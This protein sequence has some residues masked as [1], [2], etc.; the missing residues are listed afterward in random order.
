M[1]QFPVGSICEIIVPF[2]YPEL[3]GTELTILGPLEQHENDEGTWYGYTTDLVHNG[4]EICPLHKCLRLKRLPP[5]ED[6]WCREVMKK[7]MKPISIHE[8]EDELGV[9]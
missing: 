7:V 3:L 5:S 9:V 8:L 2:L 4:Y 6:A 1:R